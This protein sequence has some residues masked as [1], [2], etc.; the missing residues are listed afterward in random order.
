MDGTQKLI[1]KQICSW[2][3]GRIFFPQDITVDESPESIRQA[4]CHLTH[5]RI[6]VRLARGVYCYPRVTGEYGMKTILPTEESIAEAIAEKENV[7]IIP[8]GDYAAYRLGLTTMY[9]SSLKYLTDG[10]PRVINLAKG[11]KIYFNHTS[12]VK[13]FAF[14]SETIQMLSSAIRALGRKDEDGNS[15]LDNEEKRRKMRQILRKAS[16]EDFIHDINLPPAWVGE[17]LKELWNG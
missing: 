17:I 15:Y 2:G 5:D 4:L 8:Y 13:M 14:R 10:S 12:E 11:R 9:L 6:I 1:E 7:R 16:E 3:R